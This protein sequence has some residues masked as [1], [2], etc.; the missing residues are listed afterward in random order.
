MPQ[1]RPFVSSVS[2][3]HL[4]RGRLG[5]SLRLADVLF[6]VLLLAIGAAAFAAGRGGF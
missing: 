3:R 5:R 6:L 1:Y 2:R 4:S